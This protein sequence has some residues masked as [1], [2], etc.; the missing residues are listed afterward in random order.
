TFIGAARD[1]LP[2]YDSSPRALRF[3]AV[4]VVAALAVVL[5]APWVGLLVLLSVLISAAI[6]AFCCLAARRFVSLSTLVSLSLITALGTVAAFV[7]IYFVV[8]TAA[9]GAGGTTALGL[10]SG[11]GVVPDALR[12]LV[13]AAAAAAGGARA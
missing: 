8:Q 1:A 3:G 11:G 13:E 5:S 2:V 12:A 6:F 4:G 10:E 9:A 7:A